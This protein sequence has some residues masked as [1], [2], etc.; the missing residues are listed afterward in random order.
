MGQLKVLGSLVAGPPASITAALPSTVATASLSTKTDPKGYGRATGILERQETYSA[1]TDLGE[2]GHVV[3]QA[4]FLYFR[5]D[6]PVQLRLT[7]DDGVGGDVVSVVP[8]DGLFLGE[9]DEAKFLKQLELHTA[10]L[11]VQ[12]EYFLS[13]QQ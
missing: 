2:P 13:G 7:F 9:Y 11:P 5:S 4:H 6:G 3:T 8:V 12:F 1:F 10:G